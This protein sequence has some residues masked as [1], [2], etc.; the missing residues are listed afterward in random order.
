MLN[1][2]STLTNAELIDLWLHGKSAN[3]VDGYRRHAEQTQPGEN[4]S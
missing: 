2:S 1:S 4:H 3:T